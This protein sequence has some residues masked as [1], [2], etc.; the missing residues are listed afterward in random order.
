MTIGFR[1]DNLGALVTILD[2]APYGS[3]VEDAK[4]TIDKLGI[5]K[6]LILLRI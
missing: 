4:V 6:S 2:N 5:S 1:G 3:D